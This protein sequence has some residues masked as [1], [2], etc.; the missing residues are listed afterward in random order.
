MPPIPTASQNN[1]QRKIYY[2]LH[3]PQSEVWVC[4]QYVT[5]QTGNWLSADLQ[6]VL[7]CILIVDACN[8]C[9]VSVTMKRMRI[10]FSGQ[11]PNPNTSYRSP[12]P[13]SYSFICSLQHLSPSSSYSLSC[14]SDKSDFTLASTIYSFRRFQRPQFPVGISHN[15]RQRQSSFR[16]MC[17]VSTGSIMHLSLR[18]GC[19]S[20]LYLAF[21][22]PGL[23][24]H[25]E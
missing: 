3:V 6:N 8:W 2:L 1:P 10:F 19:S 7:R 24:V 15:R 14:R 9:S 18:S 17:R 13:L 11:H 5:S 21:C 16:C 4:Y 22:S 25:L 23:A 20:A 12:Y